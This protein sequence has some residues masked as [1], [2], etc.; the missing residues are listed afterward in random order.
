MTAALCPHNHGP[1]SGCGWCFLWCDGIIQFIVLVPSSSYYT[2][3]PEISI[4]QWNKASRYNYA[5]M[6]DSL[7]VISFGSELK[8]VCYQKCLC[9]VQVIIQHHGSVVTSTNLGPVFPCLFELCGNGNDGWRS[10]SGASAVW[11]GPRIGTS[12]SSRE[13]PALP[14]K[15]PERYHAV[16]ISARAVRRPTR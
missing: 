15:W 11:S 14:S 7:I 12:Q 4:L 5:I 8:F 13:L 1:S 3:R 2:I 16:M 6:K 9:V 10:C